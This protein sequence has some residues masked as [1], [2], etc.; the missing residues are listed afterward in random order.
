MPRQEFLQTRL[1]QANMAIGAATLVTKSTILQLRSLYKVV[2][3][4]R[5]D[6]NL[7]LAMYHA[8]YYEPLFS[9]R[10]PGM[11]TVELFAKSAIDKAITCLIATPDESTPSSELRA[12]YDLARQGDQLVWTLTAMTA[13]LNACLDPEKVAL[14]V[15]TV[16]SVR[17]NPAC[18]MHKNTK[19]G[20]PQAI[21]EILTRG[22]GTDPQLR[23]PRYSSNSIFGRRLVEDLALWSRLAEVSGLQNQA[24]WLLGPFASGSSQWPT[25]RAP[26]ADL[27]CTL[28]ALLQ[29]RWPWRV[30]IS[31]ARTPLLSKNGVLL[32]NG[33]LCVDSS[34]VPLVAFL[35]AL[36]SAGVDMHID[37]LSQDEAQ[38][39]PAYLQFDFALHRE[40]RLQH[41]PGT[42][43]LHIEYLKSGSWWLENENRNR[44]LN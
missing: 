38:G 33:Y 13:A 16:F 15:Q 21:T 17:E 2:T 20:F 30:K 34:A 41:D 11:W 29:Q 27:A 35:E 4:K 39:W 9:P 44:I 26:E 14:V 43:E 7:S 28:L 3:A 12:V 18:I 23:K 24:S 10:W 25:S 6:D 1:Q 32:R 36:K 22:E 42:P 40:L 5:R 19:R 31:T 8:W 37:E